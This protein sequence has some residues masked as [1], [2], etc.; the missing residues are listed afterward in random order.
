MSK[1]VI[2][3]KKLSKP[4]NFI[5]VSVESSVVLIFIPYSDK[6]MIRLIENELSFNVVEKIGNFKGKHLVTKV[7]LSDIKFIVFDNN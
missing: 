4:F 5:T 2:L 7:S 3:F 6:D 1:G